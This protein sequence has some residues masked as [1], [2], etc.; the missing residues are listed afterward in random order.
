MATTS[1]AHRRKIL[2]L[3]Q[4]PNPATSVQ[5]AESRLRG[6]PLCMAP[7]P[8]PSLGRSLCSGRAATLASVPARMA[9]STWG[10]SSMAAPMAAGDVL[11]ADE[12]EGAV[13]IHHR[14]PRCLLRLRDRA[15]AAPLDGEGIELALEFEYEA[16]R[17]GVD[18]DISR[19][20]LAVL[21]EASTVSLGRDDHRTLRSEATDFARWGRRGGLETLRRH[22]RG[23]FRLLGRRRHG[24][25]T[26]EELRAGM[27]PALADLAELPLSG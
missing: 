1:L 21:I 27:V 11:V 3:P 20:D 4:R 19:D 25:I 15:D 14:V 13:E 6:L 24:C 23:W 22:G 16:S 9:R 18:V 12:L 5:G 26:P 7:G 17:Y 2:P 10:G 8:A